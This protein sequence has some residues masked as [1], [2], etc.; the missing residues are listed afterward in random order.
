MTDGYNN[1]GGVNNMNDSTYFSYGFARNGLLGN[2]TSD[3]D[4]L[5]SLLD[6]KTLQACTNAK[7][8]GI[9]IYSIAFGNSADTSLIQSCASKP[10]Y[11]YFPQ[12]ASDLDPVF[13]QIAQS[14]TSLR[15]SQ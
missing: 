9:I 2:A 15:I 1:Y 10:E 6:T 5:D 8:Q 11:F 7:A 3:N 14:L 4:T 12:N 13:Q